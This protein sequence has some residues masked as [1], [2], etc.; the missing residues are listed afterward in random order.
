MSGQSKTVEESCFAR[1]GL[2]GNPSDGFKG[3]TIS[4]LISNFAAVVTLKESNQKCSG[5]DAASSFSELN[6]FHCPADGVKLLHATCKVF[7]SYCIQKNITIHL[8][9]GF[10][11]S[12]TTTIPK[13]VG[14]SGS[15]AIIIA[16]FRGLLKFYELTIADL[17]IDLKDLPQVI[18]DIEILELGIAAGLQDRVVQ[19]YGG[20]VYMDFSKSPNNVYTAVDTMLLPEMYLVYD[21]RGGED[22]G[23][24]HANV[25]ERWTNG[26]VEVVEG[27]IAFAG[28]AETALSC[29]QNQYSDSGINDFSCVN[30]GSS[31]DSGSSSADRSA[32]LVLLSPSQSKSKRTLAQ[33]MAKNFAMRRKL[34]GDDVVGR[35]NVLLAETLAGFVCSDD[36]DCQGENGIS[37]KFTGSGGAFVC[38]RADGRGWLSKDDELRVTAIVEGLGFSLLRAIPSPSSQLLA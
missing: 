7:C 29:L 6:E 4:F 3:K 8:T 20:L 27:M 23:K 31:S 1:I 37:C 26:E 16:A 12:F 28:Y 38:I 2:M 24:V 10:E 35:R 14:L 11:M 30:S 34:Y 17:G 5:E 22:S 25:K 21:T 9:K 15:S 19:T 18:L 13:M 36:S 32:A 33:L